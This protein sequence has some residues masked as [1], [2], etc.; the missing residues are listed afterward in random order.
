MGPRAVG[1]AVNAVMDDDRVLRCGVALHAQDLDPVAG[2]LERRDH[3]LAIARLLDVD[4]LAG[5]ERQRRQTEQH[6]DATGPAGRPRRHR[7]AAPGQPL[8]SSAAA[9]GAA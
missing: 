6:K 1:T 5:A 3:P 7:P 9:S 2:V 4:P 8:S